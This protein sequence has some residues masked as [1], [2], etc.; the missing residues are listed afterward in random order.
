MAATSFDEAGERPCVDV[1]GL[2]AQARQ[3]AVQLDV[4]GLSCE[5]SGL[6]SEMQ[7]VRLALL[8]KELSE[9]LAERVE[10]SWNG[11]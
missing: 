11:T 9:S 8:L 2:A 5:A 1:R 3:V 4:F 6:I 7:A 10:E